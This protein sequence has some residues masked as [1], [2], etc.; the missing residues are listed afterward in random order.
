M[1]YEIFALENTPAKL[2]VSK[3]KTDSKDVMELV[4]AHY[5]DCGFL[6]NVTIEE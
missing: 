6:V 2:C 1:T 3:T 4:K 5:E